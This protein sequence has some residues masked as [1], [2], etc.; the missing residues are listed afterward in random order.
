MSE[1]K[2]EGQTKNLE[3]QIALLHKELEMKQKAL[4]AQQKE[5]PHPKELLRE[6]VG[7]KIEAIKNVPGVPLPP[8]PPQPA[9][10]SEEDEWKLQAPRYQAKPSYELETLAPLLAPFQ[11]MLEEKTLDETIGEVVKTDNPAIVDAF[12][13]WLVEK[14]Y[15]HLIETGKLERVE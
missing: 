2:T 9:K 10:R 8:S 4:E 14:S 1:T 15:A 11:Q 6:V 3:D 5:A 7:E 12:H 13:D